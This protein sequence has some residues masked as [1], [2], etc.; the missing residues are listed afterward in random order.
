MLPLFRLP[1]DSPSSSKKR[2]SNLRFDIRLPVLRVA[3]SYNS[4]R[5]RHCPRCQGNA[6]VR[7]LDSRKQELLTARYVHAVF[8]LPRELAP[9]ALQ[10]KRVIYNLLLHASAQTLL[11]IA[12]DPRHLGAEIGFFSRCASP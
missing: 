8:T 12:R 1:S 9:L 5:N 2:R 3:I 7:W 6:R 11:E 4:C 10:Y